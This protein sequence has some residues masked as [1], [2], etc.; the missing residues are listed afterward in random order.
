M[1][2]ET[3]VTEVKE[4]RTMGWVPREEFKGVQDHWIDAKTFLDRGRHVLPI[5]Q[6]NN[7]KLL[8]QLQS[9][10]QKVS[11]LET[12][13]QAANAVID[14]LQSSHDED[15]KAQVADARKELRA[16]LAKAS[17]EG[18]HEA[19]AEL[20]DK[21]TE[22]RAAEETP[23]KVK[24][25]KET[26]PQIPQDVRDWYAKHP[27]FTASPRKIALANAIAYE[28]RQG[29]NTTTGPVFLDQ[30]AEEVDK[31]LTGTAGA[32]KVSGGNGGAGRSEVGGGASGKTY[33]D[34]PAEAKAACEKM[35]PRLVG[36]NRAHKDVASWRKSYT[37]QFFAE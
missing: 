28:L 3:D 12:S 23:G 5:L 6:S 34:L 20:T 30:V 15:V 17:R 1:S 22:L 21:L 35:A 4:A 27:E 8:G 14:A 18:D 37:E 31:A 24:K 26:E 11:S 7:Q 33:S 32:S 10:S 29:G 16:D 36:A 9:V 13:L 19:V 25:E 2:E